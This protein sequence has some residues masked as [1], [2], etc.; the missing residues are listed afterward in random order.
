MYL[1]VCTICGIEFSHKIKGIKYCSRDCYYES[2]RGVP[3]TEDF[4]TK[5]KAAL[6]GKPLTEERK[7]KIGKANLKILPDECIKRLIEIESWP[8][9]VHR[10]A[11]LYHLNYKTSSRVI[12][13]YIKSLGLN[14]KKI[15][16]LSL[17]I[18]KLH[19]EK[20][21]EIIE[22][23]KIET[24]RYVYKKWKIGSHTYKKIVEF[25]N[26][27]PVIKYSSGKRLWAQNIETWP[28][29]I[30]RKLLEEKDI[31]F[32]QEFKFG[33]YF[34]DFKVFNTLIEVQGDY[35]HANPLYF[36]DKIS[37]KEQNKN[38]QRDIKKKKLALEH[39]FDFIEI[40]ES[41]LKL[42]LDLVSKRIDK[43]NE[44]NI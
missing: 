28:E 38:L 44:R 10:K 30:V 5:I 41:D 24:K 18:Q 13:K 33:K 19:N 11:Y 40:W 29:T 6:T 7:Q 1:Y 37:T 20:F 23:I 4:K 12:D 42:N 3:R 15:K 31:I 2:R 9:V 25:Y 17:S 26:L 36:K 35:W 27:I 43:I 22:D 21:K 16:V 34:Y 14:S 39:G 8:H 32:E